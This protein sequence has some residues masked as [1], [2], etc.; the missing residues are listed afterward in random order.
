MRMSDQVEKNIVPSINEVNE[1]LWRNRSR[2]KGV[3]PRLT[4]ETD[5]STNAYVKLDGKTVWDE[6]EQDVDCSPRR[7]MALIR[8]SAFQTSQIMSRVAGLCG[9]Q[10]TAFP[11]YWK[12]ADGKVL[13]KHKQ[14]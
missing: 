8:D 3:V 6:R 5:F 9:E 12:G 10:K 11:A 14:L 2:L 4:L 7:L 13:E 1:L